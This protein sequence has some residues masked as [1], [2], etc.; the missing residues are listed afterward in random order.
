MSRDDL[1][2]LWAP[3]RARLAVVTPLGWGFVG[4]AVVCAA[5]GLALA[6][7]ELLVIAVALAVLVLLGLLLTLGGTPLDLRVELV[8][9]RVRAGRT[10][11]GRLV[12]TNSRTGAVRPATL[13]MPVGP[14]LASFR[15]PRLAAGESTVFEFDIPTERRGV[16]DVGP[17]VTVRGDP[18]GLARREVSASDLVELFVHPHLVPLPSLD[19]GL[20]RDLEGRPTQ[21][22]SV[23]DLDFHTLRA[24]VPGDDRRHIH[25]T[26]SARVSAA[27]GTT[28]FMMKSYTDTRRSH[29]GVL[30]DGRAESYLDDDAFE[31][32]V[33]AAAS[34]ATRAQ[35]DEMDVSVVAAN[36]AMDRVGVTRTLDGFARVSPSAS[37][38]SGL[39]SHLLTLA[40]SMSIA[41]VITGSENAFPD[42]QRGFSQ[43]GPQVRTHVLRIRPGAPSATSVLHGCTVLTLGDLADLG[44]LISV[45]GLA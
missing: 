4:C 31:M 24:Y 30:L 44:R 16:I 45:A 40:P 5:L 12:A 26:S 38:L 27:S 17:V 3:V 33:V 7:V 21:D 43:F 18:I 8:P 20:V 11:Y 25:W 39:A 9:P 19:A 28:T 35:R 36:H 14:D 23:A 32:A 10:A 22:P 13:E 15:L 34:I 2:A 1:Q 37:E 41:V 29:L 42:I 6:W